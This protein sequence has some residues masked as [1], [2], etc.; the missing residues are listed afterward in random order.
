M[1][2]NFNI[3]EEPWIQVID[4]ND[5]LLKVSLTDAILRS[6]QYFEICGDNVAQNASVLRLILSV[7]YTVFLRKNE[8]GDDVPIETSEEAIRRWGAIFKEGSFPQKPVLDY[9]NEH[10]DEFW[11]F[12]EKHPFYQVIVTDEAIQKVNDEK[13]RKYSISDIPLKK[14]N[15]N[16]LKSDNKIQ[17]FAT[18]S[19][20]VSN[21]KADEALR[22][23][24]L[25]QDFVDA[26]EANPRPKPGWVA[27]IG[28]IQAQGN[29]LFETL[30]Y[31]LA[32]LKNGEEIWKAPRPV[33]ERHDN[34]PLSPV[35]P[36][37]PAMLMTPQTRFMRLETDENGDVV[38]VK[39]IGGNV[40]SENAI[41]YEPMS[42]RK[43]NIKNPNKGAEEESTETYYT[44]QMNI[45]SE[46]LWRNFEHFRED[47]RSAPGIVSW[48]KLLMEN[49][50]I[51][52]AIPITFLVIGEN[53]KQSNCGVKSIFSNTVL[54]PAGLLFENDKV[55]Q[56]ENEDTEDKE[57]D[58]EL[59][60]DVVQNE[61]SKLKKAVGYFE[62]FATN[63][64]K[65]KNINDPKRKNIISKFIE[66][67]FHDIDQP[68]KICLM[69][70][71]I[72]GD[73]IEKEK[74]SKNLRKIVYDTIKGKE[75]QFLSTQSILIFDKRKDKSFGKLYCEYLKKM[76]SYYS[77]GDTD[78]ENKS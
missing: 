75:H 61:V 72:S 41:N 14:F 35:R 11:L 20:K 64:L 77:K 51:N 55:G 48:I 10:K 28:Y 16:V 67:I 57:I 52:P 24:L 53:F 27:S 31:N 66:Q 76:S 39:S 46:Q 8:N 65:L 4:K 78:H 44:A 5:N 3:L 60:G 12:D 42:F 13:D 37:D 43:K 56:Y 32:L 9:L 7:L 29:N 49:E 71:D 18:A 40:I 74:Y 2:R 63:V 23:L 36:E 68:F 73:E 38:A 6:D 70:I 69:N 59:W 54:F 15:G 22:W 21:M 30:M 34:I 50:I 33:W 25:Y 17:P 26:S 58:S 19:A 45:L 62:D 47:R 1:N